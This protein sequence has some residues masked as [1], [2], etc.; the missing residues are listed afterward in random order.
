MPPKQAQVHIP[1][2][3][4]SFLSRAWTK[5]KSGMGEGIGEKIGYLLITGICFLFYSY[6]TTTFAFKSDLVTH[7]DEVNK[8]IM[9][10][11]KETHLEIEKNNQK[12]TEDFN[13]K[14]GDLQ[15]TFDKLSESTKSSNKQVLDAINQLVSNIQTIN[16]NLPYTVQDVRKLDVQ[17][18]DLFNKVTILH[19]EV[20]AQTFQINQLEQIQK[21]P[22]SSKN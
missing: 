22:N 15:G 21:I 5:I 6:F 17:Y 3:R 1:T 10:V 16:D 18:G 11:S 14:L 2:V 4:L 19:D 12:I 8:Q 20:A 13:A 9:A 7:Q